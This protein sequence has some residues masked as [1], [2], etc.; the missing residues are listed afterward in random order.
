LL[1]CFLA[2]LLRVSFTV[3][4][5]YLLYRLPYEGFWDFF[6]VGLSKLFLIF[7]HI[8]LLPILGAPLTLVAGLRTR[9]VRE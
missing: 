1:P 9:T 8:G 7:L 2:S 5:T 3:G 4:L 6:C